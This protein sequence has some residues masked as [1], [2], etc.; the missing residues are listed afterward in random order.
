MKSASWRKKDTSAPSRTHT[1]KV[2]NREIFR[3]PA[4]KAERKQ[5]M[6]TKNT[7]LPP[8]ADSLKDALPPL[9]DRGRDALPALGGPPLRHEYSDV[10]YSA[11]TSFADAV[12]KEQ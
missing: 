11:A 8:L 4:K 2:N 6:S 9:P 3:S 1:S 7:A 5:I 12:T 10:P